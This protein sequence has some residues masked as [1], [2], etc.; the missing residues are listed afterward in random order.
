MEAPMREQTARPAL[1][2]AIIAK[3]P[4]GRQRLSPRWWSD[5]NLKPGT[6]LLAREEC[7]RRRAAKPLKHDPDVTAQKEARRY[8][9]WCWEF[10][11]ECL[12]WE[13]SAAVH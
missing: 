11:P 13:L 6:T 9:K 1:R 3:H 12:P 2:P 8:A 4:P 10:A 5:P 7:R